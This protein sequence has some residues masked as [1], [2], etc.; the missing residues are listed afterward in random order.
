MNDIKAALTFDNGK[1]NVKPF[2]IKYQD[3]KITVGGTHG[4]DQDELELGKHGRALANH[5]S[6]LST[7]GQRPTRSPRW[8]RAASEVQ[9]LHVNGSN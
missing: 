1:V 3:I 5:A 7:C 9:V 4:F 6:L 8:A 2:D